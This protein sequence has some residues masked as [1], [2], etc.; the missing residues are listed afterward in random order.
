MHG[1][2]LVARQGKAHLIGWIQSGENRVRAFDV[3]AHASGIV[4]HPGD[5]KR[6]AGGRDVGLIHRLVRLRL[7][8]DSDIRIVSQHVV[9]GRHDALHGHLAVFGFPNIGA[10][11]GQPEHNQSGIQRVG[12]VHRATGSLSG[13]FPAGRIIGRVRAV[14]GAG[15]FP[16]SGSNELGGQPFAF[17]H[18]V[19]FFGL[20]DDLLRAEIVH[21]RHGVVVV[22]LHAVE[23][24]LLVHLKLFA[25][26]D[27]L[28]DFGAKRIGAFVNVPGTERKTIGT[29]HFVPPFVFCGITMGALMDVFS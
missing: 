25:E 12:N 13:V 14:Y 6:V 23:S 22:E 20:V 29:G 5:G 24:E 2:Q 27:A 17:K 28:P 9:D 21:L 16:Q 8:G 18:A 15:I 3:D 11:A 19:H 4:G 26:L 10:F 7:D 1:E